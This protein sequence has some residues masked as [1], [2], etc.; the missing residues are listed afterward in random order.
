MI[1]TRY[2]P[3]DPECNITNMLDTV[4]KHGKQ[5]LSF[6]HFKVSLGGEKEKA[7]PRYKHVQT[8]SYISRVPSPLVLAV[9]NGVRLVRRYLGSLNCYPLCSLDNFIR[10]I[11]TLIFQ[12]SL[13][14]YHPA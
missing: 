6:K 4:R 1:R 12:A 11:K 8:V 13:H 9:L 7:T 2:Y 5:L 3:Q 14:A 10:N